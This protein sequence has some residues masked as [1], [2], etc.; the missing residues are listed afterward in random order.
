LPSRCRLWITLSIVATVALCA[1][2]IPIRLLVFPLIAGTADHGEPSPT[3]ALFAFV[4]TFDDPPQSIG[5]D[6]LIVPQRR[7][8][9]GRQRHDYLHAH[10][11]RPQRH[12]LG[13]PLR[14]RQPTHRHHH[15]QRRPRHRHRQLRRAVD[16]ASHLPGHTRRRSAVLPRTATS[17]ARRS[18]PGP[19]RLAALVGHHPALV[20]Q[21]LPL[22]RRPASP[23]PVPEFTPVVTQG[24]GG[25]GCRPTTPILA[26]APRTTAS[27][28]QRAIGT[29]G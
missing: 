10:G 2:A 18:P 27:Q 11:G 4:L 6:R 21:L 23:E 24:T 14:T 25:Q 7:A 22:R 17:L 9:L 5:V 12:G 16:P 20:R 13:R 19:H 29:R 28:L 1:I 3:A 15:H 26:P 8:K